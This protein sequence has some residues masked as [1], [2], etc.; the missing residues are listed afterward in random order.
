M[1]RGYLKPLHTA[2]T[3]ATA[4]QPSAE[5]KKPDTNQ[6][7]HMIPKSR[8]DE[9][10]TQAQELAE[11]KRKRE[12]ADAAADKQRQA[13]ADKAAHEKGEF[14]KLASDRAAR[15]AALESEHG[16]AT[17]QLT[18]YQ[19][20]MERQVKAR[21]RSL[22]EEIKALDPGGDVLTRFAWLEKAEAAA[23]KLAGQAA[24]RGTPP[25]PRGNGATPAPGSA[26][27]I[28]QKKASGDYAL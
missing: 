5:T 2:D 18:K 27:I 9:V 23:A 20:E 10:N 11:W 14:E 6:Q 19:E 28:A 26:D 7:E 17:E 16:T 22:P 25:G 3:G 24:P 1:L 13:D 8:F 4:D 21:L 15:I 12:A